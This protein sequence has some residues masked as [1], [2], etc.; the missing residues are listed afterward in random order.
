MQSDAPIKSQKTFR[1]RLFNEEEY[2]KLT[3][4]VIPGFIT[5]LDTTAP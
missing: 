4:P 2:W 3:V 1:V 5:R